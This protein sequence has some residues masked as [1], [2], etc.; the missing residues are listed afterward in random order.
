MN[1]SGFSLRLGTNLSYSSVLP[2]SLDLN[3]IDLMRGRDRKITSLVITSEE[4]IVITD[5]HDNQYPDWDTPRK[6]CEKNVFTFDRTGKEIWDFDTLVGEK[7][8]PI[9]GGFIADDEH[10]RVY[11]EFFN[12]PIV[13]SH[14]Y[15][16]ATTFVVEYYIIDL[17]ERK[18]VKRIAYKT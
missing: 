7:H 1:N 17:T 10:K 2:C 9:I 16:V 3:G 6:E 15:F 4:I 8:Y 11:S 12:V 14:R 18:F 13:P 5:T